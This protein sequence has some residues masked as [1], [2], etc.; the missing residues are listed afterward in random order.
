M[1][2]IIKLKS[3]SISINTAANTVYNASVVRITA[4]GTTPTVTLYEDT[5]LLGSITLT[6]NEVIYLEKEPT[7]TINASASI[8]CV[9][10]SYKA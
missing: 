6:S 5:T 9:S 4:D 10:V 7:Q 2:S 8:N 3:N 1:P